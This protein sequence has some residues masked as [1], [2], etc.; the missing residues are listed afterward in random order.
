MAHKLTRLLGSLEN[1]LVLIQPELYRTILSYAHSRTYLQDY[2]ASIAL[3]KPYERRAP[4][5]AN[6]FA[7][8]EVHGALTH[9]STDMDAWCGLTS[10]QSIV[11]QFMSVA[12]QSD[13]HTVIFDFDSGGGSARGCF[14]TANILREKANEAGVKL[15]G[16]SESLSASASYALMAICDEII[17]SD[18]AD[19]G[20]IG[21]ITQYVNYSEKLKEDGVQVRTFKSGKYKDMGNPYR[22]MTE[23][24]ATMIQ[25]RVDKLANTFF[26]HIAT[27]RGMSV[28][29]IKSLE[30]KVLM[31]EEALQAGLVDKVM[32]PLEFIEYLEQEDRGSDNMLFGNKDKD[33]KDKLETQTEGE[34]MSSETENALAEMQTQ[35]SELAEQLANV[36]ADKE[37][38]KAQLEEKDQAI[39]QAKEKETQA[40]LNSL[41][42]KAS[43]WQV[44]GVDAEAFASKALEADADFVAM[45]EG[46]MNKANTLLDEAMEN[47]EVGVDGEG[48]G[49]EPE[50]NTAKAKTS[51]A[52]DQLVSKNFKK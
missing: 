50:A 7:T 30:A 11:D 6:G 17:V 31:G 48:E 20:S 40:N 26:N 9:F 21:V 33:R 1:E 10:Y 27:H 44:F 51:Q 37:S 25:D 41:K 47:N 38:L 49:I 32:S 8:I 45:V 36:S 2:K 13:V 35:L 39:L 16:Y 52:V 3:S 19:V 42:E 34:E 23:E 22:D 5:V 18:D 24:E 46:A 4:S 28:D 14:N 43:A 29:A 15:I 12:F